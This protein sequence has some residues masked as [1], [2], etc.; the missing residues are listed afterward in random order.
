VFARYQETEDRKQSAERKEPSGKRRQ[1]TPI[2]SGANL[3]FAL[4]KREN[5][6]NR[7]VAIIIRSE[8]QEK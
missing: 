6:N 2:R 8:G 7:G 5:I 4:R 1:G 3:V